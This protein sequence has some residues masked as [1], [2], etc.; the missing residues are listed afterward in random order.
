MIETIK[1]VDGKLLLLDQRKLPTIE[2]YRICTEYTEAAEAIFDLTVRGAPLIG[3]TAAMGMA[4]AANNLTTTSRTEFDQ[5]LL[6]IKEHFAKQRP[7]ARNLFWALDRM[8]ALLK[9]DPHTSTDQMK[10]KFI[11]EAHVIKNDD[12]RRNKATGEW[13]AELFDDGDRVL[14]HC[15]AGAL[16][17]AGPYGTATAPIRAAIAQGKRLQV[18]ADETRPVLQGAR[19]TSWELMKDEIPVTLITDNS[20]G[21]LMAKGMIDKVI[22]G[23]D[24]IVANGDVANKIGT[25]SVAVLASYHKIPFYVAAPLSTFD[26]SLKSGQEIPIEERGDEEIHTIGKTVI[27]PTNISFKNFAF[28]ITP[29]TLV[30][31]IISEAGIARAP[32]LETMKDW[33]TIE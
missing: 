17:T 20:A 25:F 7:T 29:N 8:I 11:D 9:S 14:T 21:F 26:F 33:A 18:Y 3:V 22:V 6:T 15:N 27:A 23:S 13:G 4:L 28:D 10:K 5:Q 32:Y 31:A 24:R 16:A 1:W 30:T 12:D 2:E 19:L